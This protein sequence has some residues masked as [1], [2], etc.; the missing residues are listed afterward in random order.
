MA[1]LKRSVV[2]LALAGGAACAASNRAI[3][4]TG[5]ARWTGN[6]KS[7]GGTSAVLTARTNAQSSAYGNIT[8]VT[9]DSVPPASR[10]DLSV[11]A[12]A[13]IGN[14]LAWAIFSGPCGSPTP[15]VAGV[16]EFPNIEMSSGGGR[17]GAQL[18][19]RLDPGAEY[20]ANVYNSGRASDVSNVILCANLSLGR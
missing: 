18:H 2:S 8:V 7:V 17:I 11:T 3:M 16:N 13:M 9:I 15:P 12:P 20:H 19:F 4:S 5:V 1:L 6:F 10:V 14:Q